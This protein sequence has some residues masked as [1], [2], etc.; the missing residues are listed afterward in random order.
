MN[1]FKYNYVICGSGGY[2]IYGYKDAMNLPN[3]SYHKNR[4]AGFNSLFSRILLRLCFSKKINK[5]YKNPFSSFVYPRLFPNSFPKETLI[6][7][8]FFGNLQD[9]YQSTYIEYL[10]R[11]Y[12]NVKVVLYMQ[13]LVARNRYLNFE[14]CRN[15][16]DEIFSY[17]KS[18]CFKYGLKYHPTPMSKVEQPLSMNTKPSDFFF[19]GSAKN[20]LNTIHKI[21]DFLTEQGYVCDFVILDP[22]K[23]AQ[24][25]TGINYRRH[26]ISY[27]ENLSRVA[28]TS[29]VVEIM[30]QNADGFTP[31]LWESI[32]FDKHL[33]SNNSSIADSQYYY[34]STM[35][36]I[37]DDFVSFDT[38]WLHSCSKTP[39]ILKTSLSPISLLK[40]ID[41]Q[42]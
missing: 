42:I 15:Q 30:Q 12:P 20:R 13:D 14:K 39:E 26:P 37:S 35:H 6:C 18:D 2:Y 33:L 10:R 34:P 9:I 29:C 1:N 22:P 28:G 21:Y 32:I 36:I 25:R 27:E 41:N 31:R 3:V 24:L 4:Y 11:N 38:T 16:F 17:D 8:L 40:F 19:C 23:D 7:F 5:I